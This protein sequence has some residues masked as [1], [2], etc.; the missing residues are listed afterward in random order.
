MFSF[1]GGYCFLMCLFPLPNNN[2]RSEAYRKGVQEFTCGACPECLRSRARKHVLTAVMEAQS[3]TENC[4]ITLTY[5]QYVYD[6]RGNRIGERVSDLEVDKRDVQLFIKRLRRY[7]EYHY[8][9]TFKYRL[10]AEYGKRTHRA[11]Y[12]VLLFGFCF[13]DVILYKRSKRGNWIYQS[14]LLTK[15]WHN[16]ICTVDAVNITGKVASYC[17]KYCA[18]DFRAEGTFQLASRR[19]GFRRMVE[20]FN[21]RSY[22]IDGREYPIPR[23]VWENYISEKYSSL[24]AEFTTKYRRPKIIEVDF[25]GCVSETID[26][27]AADLNA[28]QRRRYR[29]IRDSDPVYQAYT[30]YWRS[31]IEHL[32]AKA[33]VF[34]R[35]RQLPDNRYHSYKELALRA[36]SYRMRGIPVPAPRS[37]QFSAIARYERQ[38]SFAPITCHIGANDTKYRKGVEI[39]LKVHRE[40]IPEGYLLVHKNGIVH[41]P[42]PDFARL[43]LVGYD[44]DVKILKYYAE[45]GENPFDNPEKFPKRCPQTLDGL[46]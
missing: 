13:P 8:G 19:I 41:V 9:K 31:K 7:V 35:I 37:A 38:Y 29:E 25:D 3:N 36:Y 1:P 4:M 21:G 6:G 24:S 2:R 44:S 10:T 39:A 18:K 40:T 43:P 14:P 42:N 46:I 17:S 12:H 15:I 22:W 23:S 20:R 33:S 27:V 28:A 34:D 16:G 45:Y 30:E 26:F 11:H 32:P 5:D